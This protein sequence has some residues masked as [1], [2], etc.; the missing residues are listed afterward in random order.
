MISIKEYID[1]NK[2]LKD[3][4][5]E[6]RMNISFDMF[7]EIMQNSNYKELETQQITSSKVFFEEVQRS[8]YQKLYYIHQNS[9]T[10]YAVNKNKPEMNFCIRFWFTEDK[11]I[12]TDTYKAK[13]L[14]G[15]EALYI[16]LHSAINYLK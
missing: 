1:Y 12:K 15:Y 8:R 14:G 5:D 3:V 9:K 16:S 13:P 2:V 4:F 6:I 7:I 11:L 10:V